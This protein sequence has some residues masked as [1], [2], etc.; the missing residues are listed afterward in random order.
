MT[1]NEKE[2][3]NIIFYSLLNLCK[4]VLYLSLLTKE[5]HLL[6]PLIIIKKAHYYY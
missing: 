3:F 4:T 2:N 6:I 5:L 1:R